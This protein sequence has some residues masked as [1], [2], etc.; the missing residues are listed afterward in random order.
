M[1]YPTIAEVNQADAETLYE[2]DDALAE[3]QTD[4]ERTV[5]KRIKKKCWNNATGAIR[6]TDPGMVGRMEKLADLMTCILGT[7]A[8]EL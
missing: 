7:D 5:R 3:P 4:V 2:W 8:R 1:Q 6:K